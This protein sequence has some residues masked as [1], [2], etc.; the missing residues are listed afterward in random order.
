MQWTPAPSSILTLAFDDTTSR[1]DGCATV[2]ASIVNVVNVAR[3][4][5]FSLGDSMSGGSLAAGLEN[6]EKVRNF[7]IYFATSI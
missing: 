1:D 5:F 7:D 6:C 3:A 4:L 2:S